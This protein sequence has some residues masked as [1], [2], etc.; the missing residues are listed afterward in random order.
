MMEASFLSPQD[1]QADPGCV[2]AH[3]TLPSGLQVT[4][5][6]L[7]P[8]DSAALGRYFVGLSE[9]TTSLYGPHPFNQETADRLCAEINYAEIIRFVA[10]L[11]DGSLIAYFILQLNVPEGE[12]QRYQARG[13]ILDPQAGCLVAPSVADSYQSQG[14]GSPLMLHVQQVAR[15][16]GKKHMLLMGGVYDHNA[17]ARHFYQKTGFQAIGTFTSPGPAQRT[18]HDMYVNL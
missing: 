10:A 15:R 12:Q 5:R 7:T 18:S 13:V 8:S 3:L 14:I 6:P 1:I 17:R 2:T 4:F 16:L 9:K 11:T